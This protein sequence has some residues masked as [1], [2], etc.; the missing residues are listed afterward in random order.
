MA[1][2]QASLRKTKRKTQNRSFQESSEKTGNG[3]VKS[4]QLLT[5]LFSYLLC[6]C[7]DSC[8]EINKVTRKLQKFSDSDIYD[9]EKALQ[10]I[11]SSHKRFIVKNVNGQQIVEARTT[12]KLCDAFQNG[13]CHYS[14]C[15]RLQICR[16]FLEGAKLESFILT[17]TFHVHALYCSMYV[18]GINSRN[19][20]LM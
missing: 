1:N 8:L 17:V 9:R 3:D 19:Q 11:K 18:T 13:K 16:F 4:K 5:K 20:F 6:H 10:I 12:V 14:S 7:D 15:R 2:Y